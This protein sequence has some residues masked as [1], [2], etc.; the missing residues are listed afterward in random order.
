MLNNTYQLLNLHLRNIRMNLKT[1]SCHSNYNNINY[2]SSNQVKSG[3]LVNQNLYQN[4][5]NCQNYQNY[6]WNYHHQNYQYNLNE[7]NYHQPTN[8]IQKIYSHD[9]IDARDTNKDNNSEER[10]TFDQ[11]VIENPELKIIFASAKKEGELE[12]LKGM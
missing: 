10:S 7:Q 3:I 12:A 4:W 9:R 6:P 11:R 8:R 2:W 5:R 1:S